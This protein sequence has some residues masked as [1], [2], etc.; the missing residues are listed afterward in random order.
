MKFRFFNIISSYGNFQT[1]AF[2]VDDYFECFVCMPKE[3][4]ESEWNVILEH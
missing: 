2:L 1:L 3:I 4:K